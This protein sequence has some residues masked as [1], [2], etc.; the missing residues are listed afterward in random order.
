[1]TTL[2]LAAPTRACTVDSVYPVRYVSRDDGL[3]LGRLFDQGLSLPHP[4][5]PAHLSG[6]IDAACATLAGERGTLLDGCSFVVEGR[7]NI[8]AAILVVARA[9][10]P[11]ITDL[12]VAPLYQRQG[13]GR[14]LVAASLDALHAAQYLTVRA[15]VVPHSAHANLLQQYGFQ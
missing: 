6:W 8:I 14:A 11:V 3:D 9:G 7:Q 13:I 1:M 12:A 15:T 4:A 5:M 2:I 10:A